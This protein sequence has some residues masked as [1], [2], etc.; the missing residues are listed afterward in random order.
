[1][2]RSSIL[3]IG[4][5]ACGSASSQTQRVEILPPVHSTV[6]SEASPEN[7]AQDAQCKPEALAA[8][9]PDASGGLDGPAVH[10]ALESAR[11][12]A[13]RCCNGDVGGEASVTVTISPEGY[14]TGVSIAPDALAAAA[15][16]AC[17]YASFHRV[18]AKAFSGGALTVTIPVRV[19]R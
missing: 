13:Q 7:P 1:M 10:Q 2:T 3:F 12:F 14:T 9:E 4:V 6:A 19:T 5:V 18:I 17:V 8:I 16:G 15:T 11:T